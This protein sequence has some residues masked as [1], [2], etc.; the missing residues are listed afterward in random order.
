M[1]RC[2]WHT[3][4]P[5]RDETDCSLSTAR[6]WLCQ[7]PHAASVGQ[8][9]PRAALCCSQQPV[10]PRSTKLHWG[11]AQ[12]SP[13]L[14]L[15][16]SHQPEN[17]GKHLQRADVVQFSATDRFKGPIMETESHCHGKSGLKMYCCEGELWALGGLCRH[18][19][20]HRPLVGSQFPGTAQPC[21]LCWLQWGCS[22]CSTKGDPTWVVRWP[23]GVSG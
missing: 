13:A 9:W 8:H 2:L 6:R 22:T 20:G 23:S 3:K 1:F 12:A 19:C 4:L 15:L 21:V 11:R 7:H 14:S 5:L 18:G 17:R 16:A 10:H